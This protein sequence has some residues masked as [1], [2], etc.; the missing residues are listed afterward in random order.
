M[1]K[2]FVIFLLLL[3]GSIFSQ[4]DLIIE[5]LQSEVAYRNVGVVPV[6]IN[7]NLSDAYPYVRDLYESKPIYVQTEFLRVL[8]HFNDPDVVLRANEILVRLDNLNENEKIYVGDRLLEK[9]FITEILVTRGHFNTINYVFEIINRDGV[10]NINATVYNLL[11]SIL[12]KI[13]EYERQ[14]KNILLEILLNGS[15]ED[16][17][18]ITLGILSRKFGAE[19]IG[20]LRDKFINDPS[21]LVKYLA[22]QDLILLDRENLHGLLL[23]KI[24]ANSDWTFELEMI[25][26]LLSIYG[27]P[28]D[29]KLLKDY[30]EIES[31]SISKEIISFR[32]NSFTPSNP[33]LGAEVLVDSLISYTRQLSGFN[34]I[35]DSKNYETYLTELENQKKLIIKEDKCSVIESINN[36]L[37]IVEE[38]RKAKLLTE[39]G[40]KYLHYYE[41]YI[42]ENVE[43]EF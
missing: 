16:R 41:T 32:I 24:Q 14:A 29:L 31:N 1:K 19:M 42:K 18:G 11:E 37:E 20:T 23:T 35:K 12:Y 21:A 25:D 36:F 27:T 26:T 3:Q 38:H 15:D 7:E 39:E 34:W 8:N 17:R 4:I 2:I 43:E 28:S 13:P 30:C 5:D 33:N 22:L 10:E 40:Y 9:V 6:I